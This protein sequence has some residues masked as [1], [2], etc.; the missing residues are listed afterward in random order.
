MKHKRQ[1]QAKSD[2]D[3]K[4]PGERRRG[5]EDATNNN[6]K[7]APSSPESFVSTEMNIKK[8]ESNDGL[9]LTL[10]QNGPPTVTLSQG[11]GCPPGVLTNTTV[12]TKIKIEDGNLRF[13]SAPGSFSSEA[14]SIKENLSPE[15]APLNTPPTGRNSPPPLTP[16]PRITSPA[17]GT[18]C[19]A[20]SSPTV[21]SPVLAHSSPR[22]PGVSCITTSAGTLQTSCFPNIINSGAGR[23]RGSGRGSFS[24]YCSENS[25]VGNMVGNPPTTYP[26]PTYRNGSW[27]GTM[28]QYRTVNAR[29]TP[30]QYLGST[31]PRISTPHG[32]E[33]TNVQQQSQRSSGQHHMYN[34]YNMENYNYNRQYYNNGMMCSGDGYTS[35]YAYP[36]MYNGSMYNNCSQSDGNIYYEQYAMYEQ[37]EKA[38]MGNGTIQ[39]TNVAGTVTIGP[40]NIVNP[41]STMSVNGSNGNAY[42]NNSCPVGDGSVNTPFHEPQYQS[43]PNLPAHDREG[44]FSFNFFEQ[45]NGTPCTTGSS[46]SNGGT[47]TTASVPTESNNSSDFTFL[48][49]LA[50]DFAPEYYQLS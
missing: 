17:M 41:A 6:T 18:R 16:I 36:T 12:D 31:S 25:P 7:S 21:T 28:D 24:K 4:I 11:Q 38:S 37:S 32:Y 45:E 44:S 10:S 39:S 1:S 49:N 47:A 40:N 34:G 43:T 5:V 13:P 46:V 48:S 30:P 22:P 29:G 8:E 27:N 35:G 42:F 50:N 19:N 3:K 20:T 9:G 14:A 2:D 33:Y 23:G 15:T 26:G